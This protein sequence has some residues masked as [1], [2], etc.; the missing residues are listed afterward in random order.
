[1]SDTEQP[2]S[3]RAEIAARNRRHALEARERK[4]S[5]AVF[6]LLGYSAF[7][8]FLVGVLTLSS[9]PV[10]SAISLILGTL[11]SIG[12]YR[13]WFKDDIH[14]WPVA[15]PAGISIAILLLAWLGGIHHPIP[16]L[17]NTALLVLVPIRRRA[18]AAVPNN[19]FKPKPLRGSA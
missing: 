16:I 13:V 10:D 7:A 11:Y 14:W 18:V 2:I 5:G 17:L 12:A 4:L 6:G 9:S 8:N 3:H 19:S 15:V 1:V